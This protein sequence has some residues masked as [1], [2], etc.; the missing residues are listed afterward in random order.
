MIDSHCHLDFPELTENLPGILARMKEAKVQNALCI[1]VDM[2]DFPNVLALAEAHDLNDNENQSF[3][4]SI[5]LNKIS[6]LLIGF[7]D[8]R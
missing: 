1:S 2:P 6:I 3:F 5:F 7:P 4:F 8:T